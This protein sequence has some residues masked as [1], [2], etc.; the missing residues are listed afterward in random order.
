MALAY[1]P[2][3]QVFMQFESQVTAKAAMAALQQQRVWSQAVADIAVC[4][5]LIS[6]QAIPFAQ[7]QCSMVYVTEVRHRHALS[8]YWSGWGVF[9][10]KHQRN[11]FFLGCVGLANARSQRKVCDLS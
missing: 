2:R 4:V 7:E 5:T 11:T 1:L 9:T 10:L 8:P 3:A 6:K